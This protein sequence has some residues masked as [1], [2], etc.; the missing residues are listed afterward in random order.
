MTKPLDVVVL[1]RGI[2]ACAAAFALKKKGRGVTLVASG[3]G[4]T[5]LSSG[6]WD[7][8]T[9]IASAH[10]ET[11]ELFQELLAPDLPLSFEWEKDLLL[12]TAS[13]TWK[14][15]RGAQSLQAAA[16]LHEMRGKKIGCVASR[17]WR[18]PTDAITASWRNEA[19][20]ELSFEP[21]WIELKGADWTLPQLSVRLEVETTFADALAQLL[22][23]ALSERSFDALLFPPFFPSFAVARA[24]EEKIG[25]RVME[26]LSGPEPTAGW[27]LHQALDQALKREGIEVATPTSALG[28]ETEGDRI[29]AVSWSPVTP[30]RDREL[31]A[32]EFVLATGRAL[33]GGLCFERRRV[34][35][36][37]FSLPLFCPDSRRRIQDRGE[38]SWDD[39][40]KRDW[41]RLGLR[42]D[43]AYRPVDETGDP[44]FANLRACGTIVGGEDY[45]RAGKGIG[46]AAT[47]GRLCAES[48]V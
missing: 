46:W 9:E 15:T 27:R 43:E 12:P 20:T 14:K 19:G 32:K 34:R 10:R 5:A 24:F 35:E 16:S 4:A 13:G 11:A 37:I 1:G 21:L 31:R 41:R 33:G 40:T 28:Y 45:A 3:P 2:A 26:C 44:V 47:E 25:V 8:G 29:V 6:A 18:H 42:L 7:F 23:T 38:L 30:G 48:I 36:A 17:Q 22:K 39:G